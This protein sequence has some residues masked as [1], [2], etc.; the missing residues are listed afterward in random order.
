MLTC[1]WTHGCQPLQATIAAGPAV[2]EMGRAQTS[3][4]H[5]VDTATAAASRQGVMSLPR[6][7]TRAD[8]SPVPGR[9]SP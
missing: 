3:S 6:C 7:S 4:T 9:D 1:K 2:R 5:A 8:T